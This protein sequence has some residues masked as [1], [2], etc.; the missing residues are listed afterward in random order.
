MALAGNGKKPVKAR[1]KES[2]PEISDL[3]ARFS[4]SREAFG[5][6]GRRF[7]NTPIMTPIYPQAQVSIRHTYGY[8]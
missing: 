2:S 8:P 6:A 3:D 1:L 7:D 4:A 5:P